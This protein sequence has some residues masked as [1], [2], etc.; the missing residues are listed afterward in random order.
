MFSKDTAMI[1]I[2][3]SGKQVIDRVLPTTTLC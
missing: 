1:D 2:K 3:G